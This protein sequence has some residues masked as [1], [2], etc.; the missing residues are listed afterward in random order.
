M[1]DAAVLRELCRPRPARALATLAVLLAAWLLLALAARELPLLARVPL[2]LAA[3]FAV[4]GVIQLGHDAWHGNLFRSRVVNDIFGHSFSLLFGISFSAARHAHLA[5]HRH[6]RTERDPDAYN[7]GRG[8]RVVAQYYGVAFLGLI[9]APLHFNVAYPLV[10]YP[11]RRLALH[12]VELLGYAAVYALVAPHVPLDLWLI[13]IAFA[14]PWNGLK[15]L[16]DHHANV[17]RGDRFHTATTVT[18]TRLWTLAWYGLNH[19][20]DHHLYPRVP[21]ASLPRLHTHLRPALADRG[22]PL[23]DGYLRV[24]AAA[25]RAGPTYVEHTFLGRR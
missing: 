16:A 4:N 1:I 13:P 5:H 3:G 12:A 2:W 14:S 22:A 19:H 17:W 8:A 20:L 21:G 9:L 10:F 6:N 11:R 24:F 7:A 25:L 15:S 18:T 23:F